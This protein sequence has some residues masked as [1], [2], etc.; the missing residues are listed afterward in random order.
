MLKER[1]PCSKEAM[2]VT[3]E[4]LD[5]SHKAHSGLRAVLLRWRVSEQQAQVGA[6]SMERRGQA[7]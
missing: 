7:L 6:G 5:G 4:T 2:A 3:A 1:V